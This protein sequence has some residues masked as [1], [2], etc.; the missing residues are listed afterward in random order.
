[1]LKDNEP[2]Q[3]LERFKKTEQ[4]AKIGSWEFNLS[5]YELL[6]T[7]GLY[8]IFEIP[9]DLPAEQLFEL[10]QSRIH[11]DDRQQLEDIIANAQNGTS[12]F[13]YE[14]RVVLANGERI[15]FV[16]GVGELVTS[17]GNQLV[18]TGTCLDITEEVLTQQALAEQGAY[19]ELAIKGAHLGVWDWHLGDNT[20]VFDSRWAE[21]L[22][23]ELSELQMKLET[24]ESRVHPED[25]EEAY[26]DMKAHLEGKT[27]L[28]EN[29][30]RMKHKDGHWVYILDR[31]KVSA[32][33]SDGKP[34]RFTGTHLDIT[35]EKLREA[36]LNRALTFSES[37]FQSSNDGLLV[38]NHESRKVS[39]AN[40]AFF[41][42]WQIPDDLKQ[43]QDDEALLGFA[44]SQLANPEAFIKLVEDL[45]LTPE[46][47]SSDRIEFKDGRVFDRSSFPQIFE[48][49]PVA[50]IWSFRDIT[51]EV[52]QQKRL[53]EEEK[54]NAHH[55]KLA[56]IGELAA[57]VGH[58]INN[59]LTIAKGYIYSLNRKIAADQQISQSL[60]RDTLHKAQ[61]AMDRISRIVK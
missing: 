32:Y 54:R 5:T 1:M 52:R 43:S 16:R 36:E 19:Y 14:H 17:K 45:Y 49:K 33:D 8:E 3:I 18:L 44:I 24:W 51:E 55:A 27:A 2:K 29:V 26:S 42:L 22:G 13:K 12:N 34:T 47:H 35:R 57:G 9:K 28:Y 39:S 60:L 11:P 38:V 25:L 21:I 46:K 37:L 23:Y 15:K 58:E 6:W 56:S 7:D 59:P 31:G 53:E 20:V 41:R 50:R 40:E 61:V 10:Y 48:G 4:H 30:H